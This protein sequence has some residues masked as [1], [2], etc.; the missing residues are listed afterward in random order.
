M[1]QH[2]LV[3]T[4]GST[5]AITAARL[6]ARLL[7]PGGRITLLY[8]SPLQVALGLE[9]PPVEGVVETLPHPAPAREDLEAERSLEATC[10]ALPPGTPCASI[11]ATGRPRQTVLDQADRE[12]FDSVVVGSRGRGLI[13]RM[14]LGSVSDAVVRSVRK[15]TVVGRHDT[16]TRLLVAVDGSASSRRAADRAAQLA[17]GLQVPVILLHAV[18]FPLDAYPG[19]EGRRIEQ[20]FRDD[21]DKLFDSLGP[22]MDGVPVERVLAFGEAAH[23]I[24]VESER[25]GADLVV[26][27]S[28]GSDSGMRPVLGSVPLRVAMSAEASVAIVP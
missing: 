20:R 11:A 22:A 23:A 4:D 21:A 25:R 7:A 19:E 15:P 5:H 12:E 3:P 2:T 24:L 10:R 9:A 17:R 13:A 26:L 1:F 16:V 18:E 28:R 27:G 6:A 14:L 8:V